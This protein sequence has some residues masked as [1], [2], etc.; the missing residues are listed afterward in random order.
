MQTEILKIS[1]MTCEGCAGSV[2]R[3]LKALNG[4]GDVAVSVSAGE[5]K[6]GYD[7]KLTS[8]EQLKSAVKSAGYGVS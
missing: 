5:A 1:G 8:P 2:T 3:A 6:V 4:V 7:E